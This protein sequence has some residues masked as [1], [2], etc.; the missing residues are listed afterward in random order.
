MDERNKDLSKYRLEKADSC[1]ESARILINAG[2][3]C[4]AANRSYYAIFH[5]VRAILALEGI[6]FSKH[7]GVMAYF[8]KNYVKTGIFEKEYSRI[9]R[10][11][12][13]VRS[14]ADY[15]DYYII[16]KE[17]VEQQIIQAQ[18]FRNGVFEYVQKVIDDNNTSSQS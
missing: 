11:A 3:Y 8:Q 6:D 9:L 12:F 4:G 16:S 5:S 10:E 7:A 2:D 17:K 13:D 18:F 1:L 15:D 14:D